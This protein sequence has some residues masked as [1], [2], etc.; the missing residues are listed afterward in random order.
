MMSFLWDIPSDG[1]ESLVFR[2]TFIILFIIQ[3]RLRPGVVLNR[4]HDLNFNLPAAWIKPGAKP[5]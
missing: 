4:N 3:V 2:V 5:E 1:T